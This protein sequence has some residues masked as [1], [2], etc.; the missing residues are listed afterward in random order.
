MQHGN[1]RMDWRQVLV[2]HPKM[3][4]LSVTSLEDSHIEG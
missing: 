1:A 2:S 4:V 3:T